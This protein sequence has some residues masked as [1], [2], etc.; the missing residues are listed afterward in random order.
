VATM[1]GHEMRP[2]T[3]FADCPQLDVLCVPGGPGQMDLM[4]DEETLAFLR[5][6]AVGVKWVTS[7]CTGSLILAA[8]GLLTGYRAA[9]H[10]GSLT[11]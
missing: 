7:V 11:S 1:S 2:T 10:W 8:A 3:T 5:A 9:C 6:Q 4:E